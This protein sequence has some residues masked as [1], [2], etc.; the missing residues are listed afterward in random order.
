MSGVFGY[1]EF[2]VGSSQDTS[3]RDKCVL[4]EWARY[5]SPI[6]LIANDVNLYQVSN[7]RMYKVSVSHFFFSNI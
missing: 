7:S 3:D 5:A 4:D 6:K 2:L 1:L